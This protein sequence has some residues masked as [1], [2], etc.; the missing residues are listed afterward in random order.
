M[1][2]RSTTLALAAGLLA[3][4]AAFGQATTTDRPW[5][6]GVTQD[7]TRESNVLGSPS[8]EISDTISTTS[9][10]GGLN[11][12]LGRQRLRLDATLS[13][14]R[15]K[16][17]SQRDNDGYNVGLVLDWETIERLS[18]D[19]AVRSQRRQADFNVGGITPVSIS[20]IE[21]SDDLDFTARLGD[22]TVLSFEAGGGAR[23]VSFSAPEYA[24]RE[25]KQGSA[26]L[27]V[28]YR[29]SSILRLSVGVSGAKTRFR[30]PDV[31]Q[32]TADRSKR[33]DVYIAANWVPTGA[34]TVNARIAYGKLEYDLA[35]AADFK[36]ATGS[37]AWAWRPSGLLQLTTTLARESGQEDRFR[38][39]VLIEGSTEDPTTLATDFSRITNRIGV[40]A[41]Y[42]LT[43]KTSL[44]A[45]LSYA[46][47]NLVDRLSGATGRDKTTLASLGIRWAALRTLSL[48]CH[49]AREARQA[50]G[51]GSSD[52]DND[53]V[54]CF[55]SLTLD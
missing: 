33:S 7:F 45:G 38:R 28:A 37:L 49:V 48:G 46:E 4:G 40:A 6:V 10:R 14:Q 2:T 26:N 43:G 5:Y 51:A 39:A 52:L 1:K 31:G 18:G 42:E 21:R 25:Y 54:G 22:A 32:L 47:R 17:L 24:A 9:L 29:P 11:Q 23:S 15:Y 50:S 44:S 30:S 53:R 34:S 35:S 41:T 8:G 16:E 55:G 27:G 20:N 36:G 13:H 12:H 3:Q 19:L